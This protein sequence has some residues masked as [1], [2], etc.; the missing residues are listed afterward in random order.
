MAKAEKKPKSLFQKIL[1]VIVTIIVVLVVIIAILVLLITITS[2]KSPDGAM[3]VFG[4]QM[5]TILTGSMEKCQHKDTNVECDHV[6]VSGYSV[7]HLPID[8][9]IFIELV[10]QNEQD[11]QKWYSSLKVG[12][13]L[14]FRCDLADLAITHRIIDIDPVGNGY[15]I[16]LMGDNRG[17]DGNASEQTLRTDQMD[18]S[19]YV[20]GKVVGHNLFLGK[21]VKLIKQPLGVVIVII[22][23]CLL[24][25]IVEIIRIISILLLSKREKEQEKNEQNLR[26]VEELKMQIAQ[27]Q[28]ARSI[29]N[30]EQSSAYDKAENADSANDDN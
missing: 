30:N 14:T 28:Q 24:I 20:I 23:P 11:A 3:N 29:E 4:Y 27:A 6:D 1:D 26:Q 9:M 16:T 2:K 5:R 17:D 12:D 8:T 10:P 22:A 15:E 13:V 25:V 21:L 7:G 18:N 19:N